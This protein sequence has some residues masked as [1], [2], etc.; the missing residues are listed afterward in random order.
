MT[1]ETK[2]LL[3]HNESDLFKGDRPY[4]IK[5]D[6]LKTFKTRPIVRLFNKV[7]RNKPCPCGSGLKHKHCHIEANRILVK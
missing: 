1:H 3:Q 7:G 4:T 2:E 5:W 6:G